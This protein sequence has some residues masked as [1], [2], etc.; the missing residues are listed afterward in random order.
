MPYSDPTEL[1]MEILRYGP[2]VEV[3]APESL[4]QDVAERL[5]QAAGK[6]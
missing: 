6:Y 5:R 4:R 3:L 2:D 1:I